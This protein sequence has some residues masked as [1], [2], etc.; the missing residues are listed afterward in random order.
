MAELYLGYIS[1]ISRLYLGYISALRDATPQAP[2]LLQRR[3]FPPS[4]R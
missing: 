3:L 1:A 2:A 4:S